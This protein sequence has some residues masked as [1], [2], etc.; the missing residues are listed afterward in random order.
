MIII[1]EIQ[2]AKVISS[3][4]TYRHVALQASPYMVK[5]GILENPPSGI[6]ITIQLN[7]VTKASLSAPVASQQE[8]VLQKVLY[9]SA[10]DN[11]DVIVASSSNSDKGKNA[12]KGIL[13]IHP[14][15]V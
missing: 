15:I 1:N 13:N 7:G 6:T 14:G 5:M 12:F 2:Q 9:C 3:L 11:I 8:Q 4:D 10:N